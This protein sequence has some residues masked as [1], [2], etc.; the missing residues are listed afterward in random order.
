MKIY[1]LLRDIF[2]IT[3]PIYFGMAKMN[4]MNAF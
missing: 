3:V 4:V 1:G 2:I